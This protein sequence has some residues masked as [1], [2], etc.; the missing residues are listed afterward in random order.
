MDNENAVL[1]KETL[2]DKI[3]KPEIITLENG[4]TVRR[5]RSRAPFIVLALV[6]AILWA[7]KMTG[8]DPSEIVR[9]F[10]KMLD[11]MKKIFLL[12]HILT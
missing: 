2:F 11:L 3:F 5:R 9:R 4:H 7:V 10:A 8:F 1:Y 6:I 12:L